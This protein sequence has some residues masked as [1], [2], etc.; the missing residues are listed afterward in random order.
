M[1]RLLH[2]WVRRAAEACGIVLLLVAVL[3]ALWRSAG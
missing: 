2:F 1:H 3:F